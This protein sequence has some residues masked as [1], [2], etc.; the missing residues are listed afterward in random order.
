MSGLRSIKDGDV[1]RIERNNAK[2]ARWMC[3]RTKDRISARVIRTR[4]K[5]YSMRECL[6]DRRLQWFGKYRLGI[7]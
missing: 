5:L 7:K 4:L 6:L 3:N 1:M 2:V